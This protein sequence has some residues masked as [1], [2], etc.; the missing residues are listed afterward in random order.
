MTTEVKEIKLKPETRELA[1]RVHK[2]LK[3]D[4]KTGVG[5]LTENW[6]IES[7][8]TALPETITTKYPGITEDLPVIMESLQ[9]HNTK[10]AAGVGLAF[11]EA[12]EKILHKHKDL[13]KTELDVPTIRKDGFNFEYKRTQ[14]VPSRNPDGTTGTRAAFGLLKVGYTTYAAEAVAELKKVKSHLT[15]SAAR[16]LGG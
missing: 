7:L 5:A 3:I 12:S 10:T 6:Y 11:G 9:D 8:S 2:A 16:V 1:D 13:L 14:Q 15:E 4:G